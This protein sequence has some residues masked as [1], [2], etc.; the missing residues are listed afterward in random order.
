MSDK[1]GNSDCKVRHG[2]EDTQAFQTKSSQQFA[3]CLALHLVR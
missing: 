2:G 3:A 1:L